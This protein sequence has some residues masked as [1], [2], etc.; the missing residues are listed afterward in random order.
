MLFVPDIW[1][2]SQLVWS[3]SLCCTILLNSH[4]VFEFL[5]TNTLDKKTVSLWENWRGWSLIRNILSSLVFSRIGHKMKERSPV[6]TNINIVLQIQNWYIIIFFR[7]LKCPVHTTC[8]F[9]THFYGLFFFF[10]SIGFT[11]PARSWLASLG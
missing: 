3:T 6:P 8:C 1:G 11:F 9:K 7:S 4:R 10:T 2:F 5:A